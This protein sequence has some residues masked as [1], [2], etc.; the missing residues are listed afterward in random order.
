MVDVPSAWLQSIR[1]L[2][3]SFSGLRKGMIPYLAPLKCGYQLLRYELHPVV[4]ILSSLAFCSATDY[5]SPFQRSGITVQCNSP[6]TEVAIVSSVS[7]WED[8]LTDNAGLDMPHAFAP[9]GVTVVW[10][11][12]AHSDT[13][14]YQVQTSP[15]GACRELSTPPQPL[16]FSG[17]IHATFLESNFL[18]SAH[19][20]E[21]A[22]GYSLQ[23]RR[24]EHQLGH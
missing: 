3:S 1:A 18:V 6:T 19:I 13:L 20:D 24:T 10:T 9:L 7:P 12:G 14:A 15:A 4:G 23:I 21:N 2:S 22:H 17:D 5:G 11:S 8:R 16:L